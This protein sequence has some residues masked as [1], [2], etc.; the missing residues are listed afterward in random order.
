[1]IVACALFALLVV[2]VSCAAQLRRDTPAGR[3]RPRVECLEGRLTPSTYQVQNIAYGTDPAQKLDVY[4]DTTYTNAPIVVLVHG[5]GWTTGD[6]G[7][8]EGYYADYFLSQGFVVMAPNY[9]LLTPNGSGGYNN[10]FP[11]PVDDVAA[12]THWLAANAATY[13]ANPHEILMMANSTGTQIASMIAYDPTGFGNWGLASPLK[14]AGYVGSSGIY[15]WSLTPP[16][17]FQISEYL[18]PYFGDPQWDPTEAITFVG[19]GE[20]PALIVDGTGDTFSNYQQSIEFADDLQ[21]AGTQATLQIYPG[22]AHNTFAKE[23]STSAAEQALV[24]TFL[25][26]IGL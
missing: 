13:H 23:F 14:I 12:A 9:R 25:Q 5:G 1:V 4:S 18:G 16:Q 21:A 24:T 17:R 3:V 10:Q 20:P 22:Y 8:V 19:P 15:D 6:K 2:L 11:I 26:S 7:S